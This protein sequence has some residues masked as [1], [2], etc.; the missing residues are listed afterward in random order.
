MDVPT[1]DVP[2]LSILTKRQR[3]VIFWVINGKT[4]WETGKILGCSA[5]TVKKHLQPI[6]RKL[7]VSNR[8]E[9]AAVLRKTDPSLFL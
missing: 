4:N 8:M 1:P 3:E 2:V 5:G 6:Y 7:G 9:A